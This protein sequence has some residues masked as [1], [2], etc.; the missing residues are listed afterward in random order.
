MVLKNYLTL[1]AIGFIWGSQFIFQ[2]FAL[3]S[4]SPIWIGAT[5]A[6]I[7]A[8]TLIMICKS[9][10]VKSSSNQWYFIQRDRIT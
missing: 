4:F 3:V 9:L 5:R 2:E 1:L 8:I 10:R 6:A 7:G